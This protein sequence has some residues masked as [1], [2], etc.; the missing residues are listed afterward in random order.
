MAKSL[1]FEENGVI[2]NKKIIREGSSV[3]LEYNGLLAKSGAKEVYAHLGYNEKWDGISDIPME[4][5]EGSFKAEI[6]LASPGTLNIA[7]V[8][9]AN[10]W[11]NNSGDNYSFKVYDKISSKKDSEKK[12]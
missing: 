7:F 8:D 10:N 2:L 4:Y 11:D 6:E 1:V 3:E 12:G 9:K 5:T